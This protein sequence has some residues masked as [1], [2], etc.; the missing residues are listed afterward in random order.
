MAEN[1]WKPDWET[2]WSHDL[3]SHEQENEHCCQARPFYSVWTP[4]PRNGMAYT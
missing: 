4:D 3:S 2:D 1:T